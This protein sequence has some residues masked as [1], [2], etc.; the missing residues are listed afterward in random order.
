MT[1]A[2]AA[3][4]ASSG[5]SGPTIVQLA[6]APGEMFVPI[7]EGISGNVS[8]R[9]VQAAAPGLVRAATIETTRR[10]GRPRT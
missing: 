4:P 7:V 1:Q 9:T 10:A 8:V 3:R 5:S 2:Q 6:V